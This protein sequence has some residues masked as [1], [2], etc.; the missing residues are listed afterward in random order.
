MST[1]IYM[2]VMAGLKDSQKASCYFDAQNTQVRS[3]VAW[4][5]RRKEYS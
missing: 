5:G 2:Q 4:N 3:A 1:I